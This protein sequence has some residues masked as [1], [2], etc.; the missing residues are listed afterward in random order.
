MD[1]PI[2]NG[3]VFGTTIGLIVMWIVFWQILKFLAKG[4][5]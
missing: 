2:S 3:V 1:E 5:R 4:K